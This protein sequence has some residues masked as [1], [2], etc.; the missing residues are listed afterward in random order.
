MKKIIIICI[1]FGLII[2]GLYTL[3]PKEKK[4]LK[5]IKVAEATISS[6]KHQR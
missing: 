2:T 5:T 4:E 6:R 1:I 3:K